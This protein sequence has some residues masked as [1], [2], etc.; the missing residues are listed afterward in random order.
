MPGNGF[1]NEQSCMQDCV[2]DAVGG[3]NF[4]RYYRFSHHLDSVIRD[5]LLREAQY[6]HMCVKAFQNSY[7]KKSNPELFPPKLT[8]CCESRYLRF[9]GKEAL[10]V[11]GVGIDDLMKP[12]ERSELSASLRP[13]F[14]WGSHSDS[15]Q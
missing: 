9:L 8:S 6:L 10:P 11:T 7:N 2:A 12:S 13:L 3:G 1:L 15:P 14:I 5:T 4:Q